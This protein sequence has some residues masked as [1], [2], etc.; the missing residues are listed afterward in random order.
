MT[1][2][3]WICGLTRPSCNAVGSYNIGKLLAGIC[4]PFRDT[5]LQI[6]INN[7]ALKVAFLKSSHF[8]G[9]QL[10]SANSYIY[11]MVTKEPIAT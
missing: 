9:Y 11:Y 6:S 3:T 8:I 7:C 1:Q 10:N 4:F 5:T 2:M